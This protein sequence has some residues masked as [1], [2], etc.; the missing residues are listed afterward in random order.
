MRFEVQIHEKD[1][2]EEKLIED[3]KRVAKEIGSNKLS[4]EQYL[5]TGKYS[6]KTFSD[7]FGSW[8][9]ALEKAGLQPAQLNFINDRQLLQNLKQVWK[10]LGRQPTCMEMRAPVSKYSIRPYITAFGSWNRTLE[11]FALYN[12]DMD[13]YSKLFAIRRR[14]RRKRRGINLKIRYEVL[15]RDD[16]TC[17]ACGRSPAIHKGLDLQIDHIK[18]VSEGGATEMYNLQ[19]LCRECNVGKGRSS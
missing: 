8:T 9:R 1:I 11:K 4:T 15:K 12:K 13:S 10:T 17:R 16:Y 19:T 14:R 6:K 3:L 5:I 7:R 2:S 18:P